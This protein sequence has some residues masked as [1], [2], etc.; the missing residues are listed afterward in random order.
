MANETAQRVLEL[1][2]EGDDLTILQDGEDVLE[3]FKENLRHS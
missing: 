1:V 2:E 3:G